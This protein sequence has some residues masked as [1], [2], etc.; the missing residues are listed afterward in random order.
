[1]G[2]SLAPWNFFFVLTLGPGVHGVLQRLIWPN[3]LR[4]GFIICHNDAGGGGVLTLTWYMYMCLPFEVPFRKIWYSDGW[5]FNRDERA[6]I[7]K[8]SVF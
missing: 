5:V 6:Q 1:M 4:D 8:L 7:Q 2:F 3:E